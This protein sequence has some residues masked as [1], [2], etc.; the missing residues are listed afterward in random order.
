MEGWIYLHPGGQSQPIRHQV[1]PHYHPKGTNIHTS[2][3]DKK[4]HWPGQKFIATCCLQ[5]VNLFMKGWKARNA[6]MHFARWLGVCR[7]EDPM[8][9]LASEQ[10]GWS[11]IFWSLS[12]ATG[13]PWSENQKHQLWLLSFPLDRA[14]AKLDQ[15]EAGPWAYHMSLCLTRPSKWNFTIKGMAMELK[16]WVLNLKKL[17]KF[18]SFSFSF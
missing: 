3:V 13:Q 12:F 7:P 2:F 14:A 6:P 4:T 5:S 8:A 9:V 1:A 11:I 18:F 17:A 10:T 16:R 15:P